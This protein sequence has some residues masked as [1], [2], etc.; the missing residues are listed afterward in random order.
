MLETF[1]LFGGKDP[2]IE[3]FMAAIEMI[4]TYSLIHDDLP[5][6]DN[7]EYRRGKKTTWAVYGEG[8]AVLAGDGLLNMAFETAIEGGISA[9]EQERGLYA[10]RVMAKKAGI[11]GMIGGQ[12]VDIEN[13]GKQI[14]A[15]TLEFIH[16]NKT[17]AL[18]EAS[19]VCGAIIGGADEPTARSIEVAAG[20]IG[21]AFQIRDDI[22]DVIGDEEKLGKPIGSDQKNEHQTHVSMVG[23]EQAKADVRELSERAMAIIRGVPHENPFLMD[24]LHF[25]IE[26]EY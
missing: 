11:Y 7:D 23:I 3:H 9:I 20:D 25:L 1:R 5:A 4:H 17:S 19:M 26:R 22:L 8:Q 18:I 6:M 2:A 24:L 12:T 13:E 15:Q 14:D 16:R 21:L 10:L